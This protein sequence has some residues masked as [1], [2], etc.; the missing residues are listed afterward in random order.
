[1][2][3]EGWHRLE[4]RF[5]RSSLR[6]THDADVLWH[7]LKEG[8]GGLL[9]RVSLRCVALDTPGTA[10]GG[11]AWTAFTLERAVDERPHPPAEAGQDELWLA[12]GDQLFGRVVGMDSR[13]VRLKG[14]YGVRT[15][16]WADLR[17]CFFAEGGHKPRPLPGPR[18]RLSL[19]SGLAPEGDVLDGVL[20][21]PAAK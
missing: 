7:T 18:V 4:V 9:E 5:T 19:D 15:V 13:A 12:G 20:T 21:A 2:P 11:V 17:G 14:R 1:T 10:R 8:P 16:A 6:V 3:S